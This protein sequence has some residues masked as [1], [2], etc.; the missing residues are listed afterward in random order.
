MLFSNDRF[1]SM[2][3]YRRT[4]TCGELSLADEGKK[5]VLNGWIHK[6]RDHGGIKFINLRDRHGIIQVVIDEDAPQ[7]LK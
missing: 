6:I 7:Q 3:Q 4:H 1:F 2:K 5:T